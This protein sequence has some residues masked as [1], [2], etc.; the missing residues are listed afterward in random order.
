MVFQT[1][2]S[3]YFRKE[4]DVRTFKA[5]FG[6]HPEI[7]SALTAKYSFLDYL[8][9][10]DILIYFFWLKTY[11]TMDVMGCVWSITRAEAIEL[12]W[13][14]TQVFEALLDEVIVL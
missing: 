14:V 6:I 4:I 3:S 5:L 9:H 11:C 1:L 7:L 8:A 13:K 12:I 2:A 10:L